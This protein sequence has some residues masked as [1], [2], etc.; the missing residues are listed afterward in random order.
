MLTGRKKNRSEKN[1]EDKLSDSSSSS[2]SDKE[3]SIS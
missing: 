3:V 2:G 1:D